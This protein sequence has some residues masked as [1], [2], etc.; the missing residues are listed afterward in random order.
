[1][2]QVPGCCDCARGLST[3]GLDHL[4]KNQHT[5]QVVHAGKTE[6][7]LEAVLV[8]PKAMAYPMVMWT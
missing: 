4:W 6:G 3:D 8:V 2:L 5:I 1:M 7:E